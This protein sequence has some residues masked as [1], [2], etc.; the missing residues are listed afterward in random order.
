LVHFCKVKVDENG[1]VHEVMSRESD[2]R[3]VKVKFQSDKN[4]AQLALDVVQKC[5]YIHPSRTEEIEQLLLKLKKQAQANAE[6]ATKE[7]IKQQNSQPTKQP[8]PS[9]QYQQQPQRDG[10][11]QRTQAESQ[12]SSK[13]RASNSDYYNS[14]PANEQ[15]ARQEEDRYPPA[16]MDEL[17]DYLEMLYEVSGKSE[18][19]KEEGL[20]AQIKGTAMIMKLCRDVMN[21]EQLIQNGTVMGALT[22]VFQD[23]HKKSLEL[24]FNLLR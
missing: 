2:V 24:T 17:D 8:Q 4:M 19:E 5:K 11:R 6:A 12:S 3:R 22:R 10:S 14:V 18:K 9:S 16:R 23:E 20:N 7:S 21:L 1:R 15:Q 13:S